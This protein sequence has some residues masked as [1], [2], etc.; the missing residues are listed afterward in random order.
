MPRCNISKTNEFSELWSAW[1]ERCLD[2]AHQLL[3]DKE[4]LL[5]NSQTVVLDLLKIMS[6][7]N[8][9]ETVLDLLSFY[10]ES[11]QELLGSLLLFHFPNISLHNVE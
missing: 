11:W 9:S 10:C 4:T 7:Y 5:V 6:G 2:A 3:K 1:K 8:S